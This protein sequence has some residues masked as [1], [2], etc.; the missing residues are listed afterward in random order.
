MKRLGL[1]GGTGSAALLPHTA[2]RERETRSTPWGSASG[3]LASWQLGPVHIVYL[4]RHGASADIPPHRV[5]YRANIWA[6]RES[7]VDAVIGL[8]AVGGITPEARP[9]RIVLPD[10]LVDYTWGRE[11]SFFDGSQDVLGHRLRHIEF[12]PPFDGSLRSRMARL[13]RQSGLDILEPAVYGVTQG[14]RLETA[15]EINRLEADGCHVVGMTAMPEAA[16]AR[17]AGLPYALCA[18]VV[19]HAAGRLSPGGSI[20]AQLGTY[21][22][23]AMSQAGI[24]LEAL[25]RD[26]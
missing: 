6:L 21:L 15:A 14:P 22:D 2:I 9:G 4:P 3:Q 11:H 13:A 19:N 8:N 23:Q 16:L 25:C 26:G 17:E 5:N 20:H 12:D 24:L 18:A 7:R 10:Q 1:I